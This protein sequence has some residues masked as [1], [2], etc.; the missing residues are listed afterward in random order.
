MFTTPAPLFS[1]RHSLAWLAFA[2]LWF[3]WLGYRSLIHADEGRYAEIALEMM[4]SGDWVTPHLNGFLYFEKPPLQYWATVLAY[5]AF[6]VNEFAARFWT[7]L[8]GFLS[9]V[10][11]G[12]TAERL[13]EQRTGLLAAI[14]MAGMTWA[15]A[16]GH[17]N[18]LD[19]GLSFFLHLAL[20]CLLLAQQGQ[21]R[22]WMWLCWAAM[23]CAML[24]KGLIGLVIPGATLVGYSLLTWDW[25]I[26]RRMQWLPGL[27]IFAL[28][29]A[30]WFVLVSMRNP[31]FAHFFFIHEHFERFTT[32]EHNRTGAWWYFIPLL[33]AGLLPWTSLFPGAVLRGWR[34]V[35]GQWQPDFMLICWAGFIFLFFSYSGSKLPSY[36]LPMFGALALLI[37]RHIEHLSPVQVRRHV[38]LPAALWLVLLA[39]SPFAVRFASADVPAELLRTFGLFIGA[40]ALAFLVCTLQAWRWI[41][42]HR[43]DA[44]IAALAVGSL[45][46]VSLAAMGHEHYA[47]L[48]TSK[49]L[50]AA[51]RPVLT[52]DTEVFSV[53]TYEQTFPFYLGHT[54][55]LV[56]YVDE[57]EY[58]WQSHPANGIAKLD[59]FVARWNALPHA[60][61]MMG[62]DTYAMLSQRQ[63]PM[64]VVYRDL[65]RIVAVK[66]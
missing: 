61:A 14:V 30:P 11:T 13:W 47:R 7:A 17:Y 16:N 60:M 42:A 35:R 54:V 18:T 15:I 23:A 25:A 1:R 56:D 12:Y 8:C 5:H 52:P 53:R 51:I 37:A 19:M 65:H 29:A 28:I 62:P 64:K 26:W 59:D 48:K 10:V 22:G 45:L 39:V 6:G 36:I 38:W 34:G 33:F 3:G 63:L 46:G 21:S 2:V 31:G 43:I 41:K 49:A 66:P 20:C 4:R 27:A 44:G 32:T 9:V 58:G 55:T 57:F 50:V 40:G 24:S